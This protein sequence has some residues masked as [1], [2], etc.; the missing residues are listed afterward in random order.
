M[1]TEYTR[2]RN[3]RLQSRGSDVRYQG[4]AVLEPNQAYGRNG[5]VLIRQRNV[6]GDEFHFPDELKDADF[7]YQWVT[8]TV[9]GQEMPDQYFPMYQAGWRPVALDSRIGRHFN[10]IKVGCK[11]A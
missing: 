4:V 2:A 5:E 1:T 3:A 9:Y 11:L 8:R 10:I 6:S 7:D